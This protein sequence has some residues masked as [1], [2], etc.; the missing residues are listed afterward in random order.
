MTLVQFN[1][2]DNVS[3]FDSIRHY[4][5]QGNEFWYA[6]E[7]MKIMGYSKWERFNGVIET[8]IENL[9]T[10]LDN[11]S[12]EAY[13]FWETSG[14]TKRVNY[15]L[16]RLAVEE[17]HKIS[18][19]RRQIKNRSEKSV[20]SKLAKSI[21]FSKTEVKTLSGNIDILTTNE[22]IE[23]KKIESW[24]HAVGQVLVYSYYY[25][26]HQKRIHLYGETQESFLKMIKQHCKK[27]KILVTWEL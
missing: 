14:K 19:R 24:K 6:R 1:N 12:S 11:V 7:L 27:L 17:M 8:A 5:S 21:P 13:F 25:P 9:G 2:S 4:D 3:P 15:K 23:V 22:I 26:S 18:F 20:Q 10:L 16:S